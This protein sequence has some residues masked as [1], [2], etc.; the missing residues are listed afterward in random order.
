MPGFFRQ[1]FPKLFPNGKGD[2]TCSRPGK[3]VPL[4]QWLKHLLRTDRRFANDPIFVM[5]ASNII[6]RHKAL[7]LGN[8]Y[9]NKKASELTTEQLK[10]M[11]CCGDESV[12]K[13]LYCFTKSLNGSQQ[14]FSHSISQNVNL[15]R[16]KRIISEEREMFNLF[17][18]FSIA[19]LHDNF[20]H[21]LLPKS[22]TKNYLDKKVV[23]NLNDI[24]DGEERSKY[25]DE[26]RDI[27]LRKKAINENCDIC[28][29]Y[30][31]KK[32]DLLWKHV[33]KPVL[34]ARAFIKRYEFQHRGSIHCH[35]VLSIEGGPSCTEMDLAKN[36]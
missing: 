33:F 20:L 5:V 7:T 2:I 10:E 31:I 18:T 30:F 9:A 15:L 36:K 12:L 19:D 28:N 4:H 3:S 1:S 8:V 6:Q 23:K 35:M 25:I 29:E 24:P 14:Y 34:S 32:L 11:V 22:Y 27:L 17:L 26:K 21:R 16:H 13:S